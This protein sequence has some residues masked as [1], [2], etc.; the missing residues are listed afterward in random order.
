M[1]INTN[2]TNLKITPQLL[3][4]V[5]LIGMLILQ[6]C[7]Y[8]QSEWVP[9]TSFWSDVTMLSKYA[10]SN[11]IIEF[12]RLVLFCAIIFA[13]LV[14]QKH[15]KTAW[16]YIFALSSFAIVY[17][18][19]AIRELNVV[20]AIYSG[21]LPIVYMLV[22]GFL[23]GQKKSIW[24]SV[25]KL[26]PILMMIYVM[27]FVYEFV[28]SYSRFGW[29]IY[30][31]SSM[32]AYY[33]HLFWLSVVYIYSCI[34]DNKK[35]ILIY[36]LLVVLFIGAILLRSRSWVIQSAL[37]ILISSFTMYRK[38][39]RNLRALIKGLAIVVVITI[40]IVALL[41]TFFG[42]FVN[43][44]IEKGGNDTRSRNYIEMLEQVEPYK[45]LFGQGMTATYISKGQ[46]YS[47]IDNELFY[48]S[49]HYGVFFAIIYFTPYLVAIVKCIQKGNKMQF[50][51]FSAL[52]IFLWVASVNGLSVFNRIHLDI[53]SF[54]MPFLAG[55]IYQTAIDSSAEEIKK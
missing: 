25:K 44:L 33:S 21:N 49:F 35:K 55:H 37:L 53:K 31:N 17:S 3:V 8:M 24:E 36:P 51:L 14:M 4:N 19:E 10:E 38:K 1:T 28:D 52:L 46:D 41:N 15:G 6:V 54:V 27:L 32:M 34:T 11:K 23:L 20:R 18:F 5:S 16:I 40:V 30:S 45:W 7:S 47:F 29:V 9:S 12:I 13:S 42:D 43:S 48:M 22:F 39:N 26:L 50:W 2:T